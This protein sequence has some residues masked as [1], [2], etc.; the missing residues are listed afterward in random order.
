MATAPRTGWRA[1]CRDS[2][3]SEDD[4]DGDPRGR[5]HDQRLRL[6]RRLVLTSA[7]RSACPDFKGIIDRTAIQTDNANVSQHP[8]CA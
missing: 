2:T 8:D 3:V 1:I 7:C 6:R 4:A 5:H